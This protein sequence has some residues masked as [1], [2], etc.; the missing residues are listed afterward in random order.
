MRLELGERAP[1]KEKAHSDERAFKTPAAF[2][3]PTGLP[4]Q[5]HRP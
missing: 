5:Y 1:K 2:Y 4:L 3:S